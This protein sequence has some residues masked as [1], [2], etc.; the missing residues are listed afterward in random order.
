MKVD[1]L[2]LSNTDL[3]LNTSAPLPLGSSSQDVTDNSLG[4]A[5]MSD[6]K[7]GYSKPSASDPDS[8]DET[9]LSFP[10]TQVGGFLG[11]AQGWER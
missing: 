1:N 7:R 9:Y 2:T 6:L 10:L 8:Y 3:D 11:R 5:S 4:D